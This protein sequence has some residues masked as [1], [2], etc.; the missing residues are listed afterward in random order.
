MT[1]PPLNRRRTALLLACATQAA[2]PLSAHADEPRV[3]QEAV[4]RLAGV[5]RGQP[6]PF[7]GMLLS[8]A[9]F[10]RY[11][12]RQARGDDCARAL[13]ETEAARLE[14]AIAAERAQPSWFGRNSFT[15][16]LV[17]GAL[18]AAALAWQ[19]SR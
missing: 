13:V 16:G 10:T 3:A 15:L 19:I 1:R 6:A 18:G 11:L 8:D 17:T 7:G 5:E 14:A 12:E 9:L 2:L 4:Q